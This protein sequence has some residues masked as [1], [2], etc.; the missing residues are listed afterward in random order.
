MSVE[1]ALA[2]RRSVR[3]YSSEPLTLEELGQLLWAAQGITGLA[4][5]RSRAIGLRPTPSAGALY[6]LELY[7]FAARIADVNAGIYKY[8]PGPGVGENRLETI[9]SG[10][11]SGELAKVA[12]DQECVKNA[13]VQ[14][15]IT[16]VAQRIAVKYGERAWHYT[17]IEVGHAAQNVC[18][19]AAAL[20][21]GSVVVGAFQEQ[22]VKTLIG[23]AEEPAYMVC[24]G[25]L[26][27]K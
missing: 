5:G 10:D 11:Y 19:Q 13:A 20:G 26:K 1:Q 24:V 21:L 7:A 3:E 23:C 15:V 14:L 18:L 4:Q 25:Q 12:L 6:P 8:R 16:T 22:R 2:T 17:L 9:K 27:Q